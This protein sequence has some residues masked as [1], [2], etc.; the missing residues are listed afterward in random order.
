M[1][2]SMTPLEYDESLSRRNTWRLNDNGN[3]IEA[4][5]R[6]ASGP[7]V[8]IDTPIRW[9]HEKTAE[10][11]FVRPIDEDVWMSE[12]ATLDEKLP[13]LELVLRGVPARASAAFREL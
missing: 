8:W 12:A 13:R 4:W 1:S 2:T 6:V 5:I 7:D 11:L 10:N 3:G 9:R